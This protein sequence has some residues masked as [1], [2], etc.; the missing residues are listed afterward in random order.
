[1]EDQLIPLA[2]RPYPVRAAYVDAVVS[3][4][5]SPAAASPDLMRRIYQL[6]AQADLSRQDRLRMLE[7][8]F[9]ARCRPTVSTPDLPDKDMALSLV[10]DLISIR[11]LSD[12]GNADQLVSHLEARFDIKQEQIAFLESWTQWENKIL[13]S[14]GKPGATVSEQGMPVELAKKGTALAVQRYAGLTR[15]S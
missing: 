13:V 15:G 4:A 14:L 7:R 12:R 10:R 1:M 8:M 5:Q 11:E 2:Q 9:L 3:V 6:F